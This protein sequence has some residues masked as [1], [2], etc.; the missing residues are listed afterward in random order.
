MHFDTGVCS[1]PVSFAPPFDNVVHRS[2]MFMFKILICK[3]LSAY[4]SR[5]TICSRQTFGAWKHAAHQCQM[6]TGVC[7]KPE[8]LI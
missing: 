1:E 2:L 8:T 6:Y 5:S 4:L 3:Q 7:L